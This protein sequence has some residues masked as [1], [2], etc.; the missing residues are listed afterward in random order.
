MT[1]DAGSALISVRELSEALDSGAP[2]VLIDVRWR[3]GLPALY[4]DYLA[5]HIPGA[6]WCD[7]DADLADP[8]GAAGRHPLPDP[9]RLQ[10]RMREWGIEETSAVVLYDGASSVAAA[11]GWWVLRWAGRSDVRVLNGGFSAWIRAGKPVETETAPNKPG[12]VTIEPGA[13]AALSADDAAALAGEGR[14]VDVRAPE[15]FRG[16]VEPID[17][18]AGH[19]PGAINVPN[20]DSLMADG[21]FKADEVLRRQFESAALHRRDQAPGVYCG[22]GVAAA[23]SV[24]A[25][26]QAGLQAILYPGS[27]S[28][29]I[30]DPVRPIAT[31]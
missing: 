6:Q 25:M 31:G 1:N 13:V 5:G 8:A 10:Q 29:W 2:P 30:T 21:S 17:P 12:T 22:S 26:H 14:L 15:R 9:A 11:R 19:I 24:L 18:V 23:H 16:E 28:E 27:W 20:S 3:A 7:L 4:S